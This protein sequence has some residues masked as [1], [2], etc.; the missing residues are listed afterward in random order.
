MERGEKKRSLK[1][2][3][4]TESWGYGITERGTS[5]KLAWK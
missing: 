2:A 5:R 3:G 1:E 4:N